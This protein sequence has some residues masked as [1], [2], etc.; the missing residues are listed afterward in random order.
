MNLG[1]IRTR[2]WDFL[3]EDPT[4]NHVLAAEAEEYIHQGHMELFQ[5]IQAKQ[6]NFFLHDSLVGETAS[7]KYVNMPSDLYK[8]LVLVR[9]SGGGAS[10]TNPIALRRAKMSAEELTSDVPRFFGSSQTQPPLLYVL[11][12]QGRV[13]LYPTPAATIANSIRV[14]YVF[15]PARMTAD[16][17]D[18]LQRTA[19]AAGAG[20]D[21]ITD[22][23]DY[24]LWYALECAA[25]KE[26]STQLGWLSA[27]RQERRL[28][29]ERY[30]KDCNSAE[31][32][33]VGESAGAL[34]DV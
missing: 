28:A 33:F 8:M 1:T 21:T 32:R 26:E 2:F 9:V 18:P 13:L 31:P 15:R 24:I 16:A 27:K 12:G 6:E 34:Y 11:A 25:A 23:H 29:L 5:A 10:E 3:Q 19:G 20:A 22:F 17:H 7:T 14:Y 4:E 30:L